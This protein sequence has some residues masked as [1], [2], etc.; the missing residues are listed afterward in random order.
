MHKNVLLIKNLLK[1]LF[2]FYSKLW[3]KFSFLKTVLQIKFFDII[4]IGLL[5]FMLLLEI[6]QKSARPL[7]RLR[8]SILFHIKILL[9]ILQVI[10]VDVR[11]GMQLRIL[12]PDRK[13][14]IL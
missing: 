12:C 13:V 9:L 6:L 1:R 10:C 11:Y 8:K 7:N 14:Q 4:Q 5:N 2:K 3:E